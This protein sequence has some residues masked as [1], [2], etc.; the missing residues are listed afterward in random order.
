ML[1]AAPEQLGAVQ[2]IPPLPEEK[3]YAI[4]SLAMGQVVKIN[5]QFRKRF[6]EHLELPG[7]KGKECLWDLGFIHSVESTFPTWWTLLPLRTPFIVGWVG[8]PTAEKLLAHDENHI[9]SIA[10]NSLADILDVTTSHIRE[11]LETWYL[12]DW[13]RDPFARGA[14]SYIPVKGLEAQAILARGVAKTLFFAGEAINLAGDVG[15]V[16]GAIASGLR[17][18][19]EIL[20]AVG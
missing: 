15:T 6:W 4:A 11:Y 14:Y 18:A 17:A 9:L 3:Q 20:R 1:K 7:E 5:L 19:Q 2:F 13:S 8:G 16:H 12:H 10:I